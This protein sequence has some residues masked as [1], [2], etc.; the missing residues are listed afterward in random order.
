MTCSCAL[1]APVRP[2]VNTSGGLLPVWLADLLVRIAT[3][4]PRRGGR[5]GSGS[6]KN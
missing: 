6:R 4:G 5:K 3:G 2:M 1:D